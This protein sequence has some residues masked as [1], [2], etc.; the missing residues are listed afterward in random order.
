MQLVDAVAVVGRQLVHGNG[1]LADEDPGLAIRVDQRPPTPNDVVHLRPVGVVDRSLPEHLRLEVVLL[2][3]RRVVTQQRIFDDDVAH[4]DPE[5]GDAPV[6]PKAHDP[7]EGGPHLLVPPVQ[8]RL[9]GKM[10]VQVGLT[11]GGVGGPG[12]PTETADPIVGGEPSGLG[13][14]HTYQSRLAEVREERDSTN[15]GC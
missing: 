4:V 6:A 5:A 8:V 2:G 10:V 7:V 3:R 11:R 14:A 1:R 12:R 13:S 9:L 15:H